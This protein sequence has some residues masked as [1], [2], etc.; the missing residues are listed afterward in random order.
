M[1]VQLTA[2]IQSRDVLQ[3]FLQYIQDF[4]SAH[5]DNIELTVL[6]SCPEF[7]DDEAENLLSSIYPPLLHKAKSVNPGEA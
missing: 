5:K 6:V 2:T 4:N 3:K 7:S 1:E